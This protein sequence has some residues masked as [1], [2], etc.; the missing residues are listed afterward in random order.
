MFS[1]RGC[2]ASA[3]MIVAPTTD[4]LALSNVGIQI[5]MRRRLGLAIGYEGSDTHGHASLTTNT[6]GGLNARHTSWLCA[7]RQVFMEARGQVADRN[8]ERMLRNT[9][10][11][12]PPGDTRRLDLVVP[13][14]NAAR[15]LP[16]F[17]M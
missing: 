8:V 3:W 15:G 12:V 9:H 10:V 11:L 5:A 1:C 7:W 14:L 13:G 6:G 16:C 2:Y 4:S 17:A